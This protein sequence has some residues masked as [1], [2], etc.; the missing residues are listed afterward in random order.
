MSETASVAAIFAR[1]LAAYLGEH[2]APMAIK[3][4]AK[5][6]LGLAPDELRLPD[7]SKLLEAMRPMLSTLIGKQ[8]AEE[9]AMLIRRDLGVL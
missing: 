1:H 2:T 8:R 5:R 3:T 9:V 6:A 4:F 7:T